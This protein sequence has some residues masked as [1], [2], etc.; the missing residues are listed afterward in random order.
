MLYGKRIYESQTPQS[1]VRTQK[2][3]LN[4]AFQYKYTLYLTT[5]VLGGISIFFAPI[6]YFINQNYTF[7]TNL[8]YDT[9]P[10][11]VT[12]L[13]REVIWL[14]VFMVVSL[15]FIAG[16]TLAI[17]LRMTKNLLS[18][19]VQMEK[20]MKKLMYGHWHI[21]D[22]KISHEDDF[23][24]LALT[25]DYFYRSLKANTEAELKLIEKLSIDPQN[26][27][28][29]AAWKNLIVIKRSL[30]GLQELPFEESNVQPLSRNGP[31]FN[32]NDASSN[33]AELRRRV[34]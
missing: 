33:E 34:S 15:A 27:E 2:M 32:G 29:Y 10:A 17:G 21:P 24:D 23:R 13:E 6:Y 11:L 14:S 7:F 31:D 26:R 19:L 12:H 3:I 16:M 1:H 28:A 30:L 22:Y 20:H 18:P 25:Y 9:H 5:A 4:K 8:A